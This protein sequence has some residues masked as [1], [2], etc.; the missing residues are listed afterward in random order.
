MQEGEKAT[1]AHPKHY[2]SSNLPVGV[3]LCQSCYNSWHKA[4]PSQFRT[5]KH[6]NVATWLVV[7]GYYKISQVSII[8]IVLLSHDSRLNS[9]HNW[10]HKTRTL[11]S[12][13]YT[14][15]PG[16]LQPAGY[17]HMYVWCIYMTTLV[18]LVTMIQRPTLFKII[19]L[20]K[21]NRVTVYV[22]WG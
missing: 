19:N 17:I 18:S 9:R 11:I 12:Y 10:V 7:T 13:Y 15:I 21:I 8:T 14:T 5:E 20:Q 3:S 6:K 1:N 4:L 16:I 22:S 2:T